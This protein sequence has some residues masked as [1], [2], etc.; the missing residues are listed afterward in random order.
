MC[1]AWWLPLCIRSLPWILARL[2]AGAGCL[3]AVADGA[4]GWQSHQMALGAFLVAS[5]RGV[6]VGVVA[7]AHFGRRECT[8]AAREGSNTVSSR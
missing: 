5:L 4:A 8:Q 1:W 7:V 6:L 3:D 2:R